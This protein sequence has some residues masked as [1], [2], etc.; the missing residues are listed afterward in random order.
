MGLQ[1]GDEALPRGIINSFVSS[2]SV[3]ARNA[4]NEYEGVREQKKEYGD[5]DP[6]KPVHV[7]PQT[8][9]PALSPVGAHGNS[10]PSSA[11]VDKV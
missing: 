4:Q 2:Q 9:Q 1:F 5:I 7:M 6:Q 8:S 10:G 11:S 3:A